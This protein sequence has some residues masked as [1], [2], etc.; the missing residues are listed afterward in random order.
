MDIP[1]EIE[2]IRLLKSGS[3]LMKVLELTSEVYID[4]KLREDMSL[5][6]PLITLKKRHPVVIAE[7]HA[8]YLT[9]EMG[10]MVHIITHSGET[11]SNILIKPEWVIDFELHNNSYISSDKFWIKESDIVMDKVEGA[12]DLSVDLTF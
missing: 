3:Q 12:F 7:K 8:N 9:K 5:S 4:G 10:Y 6:L 2:Q 11:F 1:V